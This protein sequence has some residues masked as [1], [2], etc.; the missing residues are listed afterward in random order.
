M[1]MDLL[2][3]LSSPNLD[4]RQKILELAI[5]VTTKRNVEQVVGKLKKEMVRTDN[6]HYDGATE[7]RRLLVDALHDCAVRFPSVV[8][9]VSDL[10]M[11]YLTEEPS[12]PPRQGGAHAG[13]RGA[14][15]D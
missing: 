8:Q 10:L 11:N 7:Y 4:L 6:P 13:G 9:S 14:G 3:S 1:V 15:A 2:R 12:P 5:G